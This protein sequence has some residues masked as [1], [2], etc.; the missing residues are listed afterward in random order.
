MKA[1]TIWQPY[2]V[3]I[4]LADTLQLGELGKMVENRDWEPPQ[5]LIGQDIAIH[6]AKRDFDE[7][8]AR[9]V[10]HLLFD[11]LPLEKQQLFQYVFTQGQWFS[12]L[13][14]GMG[15]ILCVAKLEGLAS[16]RAELDQSQ[17]RWWVGDVGW[18]LTHI[19]ALVRPVLCR[20]MQGLW[21][22]P[23]DELAELRKQVPD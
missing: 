3:A 8:E 18:K 21:D 9:E 7:D 13:R 10:G 1:L 20:G 2:A 22:V 11:K 14:A 19:R 4:Q 6:A 17:R 16:T 15:R 23:K 5:Q 12:K